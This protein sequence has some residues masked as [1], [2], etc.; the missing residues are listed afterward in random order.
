VPPLDPRSPEADER[1][2]VPPPTDDPD[3]QGAVV[4]LDQPNGSA[5]LGRG[6]PDDDEPPQQRESWR[7]RHDKFQK[8]LKIEVAK[9][10]G[11]RTRADVLARQLADA[12]KRLAEMSGASLEAAEA[13]NKD[14]IE[15]AR[16]AHKAALES[17]DPD[18]ITE[19]AE[20]LSDAKAEAVAIKYSKGAR[21][22][23][24][25]KARKPNGADADTQPER[26]SYTRRT[27]AWIDD[28][29]WFEENAEMRDAAAQYAG[30]VLKAKKIRPDTDE[31]FSAVDKF[32]RS[33]F[34]DE[35]AEFG[36][37]ED[38][39]PKGKT[40]ERRNGVA[41]VGQGN[42]RRN[43]GAG[44]LRISLTAQQIEHAKAMG[45]PQDEY[46]LGIALQDGKITRD[47]Y[48]ERLVGL[49]KNRK[50]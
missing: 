4:D 11:E 31:Y 22:P 13:A 16:I 48:D 38:E 19:A 26:P 28:N 27:Q 6:V 30:T 50:K 2:R 36:E 25:E 3:A 41:P 37:V 33:E 21:Q 44:T 8:R 17:G 18:K 5:E 9:A 29:P 35:M 24:E 46:A 34:P 1:T 15:A 23:V 43:A 12:N 40:Q 47:Q 7:E 39:Q 45:T 49:R 14:Q 32:M 20:R 10:N 42:L